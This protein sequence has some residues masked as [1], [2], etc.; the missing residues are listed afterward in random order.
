MK[1]YR[2]PLHTPFANLSEQNLIRLSSEDLPYAIIENKQDMR[3]IY[4]PCVRHAPAMELLVACGSSHGKIFDYV[5]QGP[6]VNESPA[7]V[8]SRNL[9]ALLFSHEGE[10]AAILEGL[11]TLLNTY[12]PEEQVNWQPGL[13]AGKEHS[14]WHI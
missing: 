7:G 13:E 8:A 5:Q 3:F 2:M 14:I 11:D 10:K 12:L 9:S 1:L 4:P 6:Q